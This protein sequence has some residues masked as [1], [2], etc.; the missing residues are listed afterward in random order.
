MVIKVEQ[1]VF[2]PEYRMHKGKIDEMDKFDATFFKVTYK[3]ALSLNAQCRQLM[4]YA[5]GAVYDSGMLF[6]TFNCYYQH[7]LF[8]YF[9]IIT[10]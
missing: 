9:S 4:S 6:L 3:Q 1:N 10:S 7:N 5:Y 2:H 8:F